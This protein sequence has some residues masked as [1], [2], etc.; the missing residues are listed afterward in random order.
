MKPLGWGKISLCL[1][2]LFYGNALRVPVFALFRHAAVPRGPVS[3]MCKCRV[4]LFVLSSNILLSL[5][6]L[7]QLLK[8]GS[9]QKVY[10][11]LQGY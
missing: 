8:Q 3:Q 10:N 4:L 6:G 11:G 7:K 5:A 2:V 9:V 1:F